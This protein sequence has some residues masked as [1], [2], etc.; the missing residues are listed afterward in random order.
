MWLRR[1]AIA[2]IVTALCSC[3]P[4][5]GTVFELR[6]PDKLVEQSDPNTAGVI[7]QDSPRLAQQSLIIPNQTLLD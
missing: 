2:M 1:V 5:E 7:R 4:F 6:A 3:S